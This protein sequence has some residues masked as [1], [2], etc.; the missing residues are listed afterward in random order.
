MSFFLF[1]RE[2]STWPAPQSSNLILCGYRR[3]ICVSAAALLV[4]RQVST[5]VSKQRRAAVARTTPTESRG[6]RQHERAVPQCR[7]RGVDQSARE[8]ID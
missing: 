4:L 6:T 3:S 8:K 2:R 7:L 1:C 5:V